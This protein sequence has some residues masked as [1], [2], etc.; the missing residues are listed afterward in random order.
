MRRT[1]F[2]NHQ[3]YYIMNRGVENRPLFL[4]DDDR[5]R[6]LEYMR[7]F[8]NTKEKD[9]LDAVSQPLVSFI[10]YVLLDSEFHLLLRQ[11][12]DGGLTDFMHQLGTG[13]SMYFNRKAQRRGRLFEGPFRAKELTPKEIL[14]MTVYIHLQP[15]NLSAFLT[16]HDKFEYLN[17]YKWSSY[18][19]YVGERNGTLCDKTPV[20]D[21]LPAG[22]KGNNYLEM[23]KTF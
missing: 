10:A 7:R 15:T 21:Q 17:S 6:F 18:P 2:S 19:D 5:K 14:G 3:Y 23:I 16:A 12:N 9:Y 20:L 13:Y 4:D 1:E 22:D 11:E 8:R